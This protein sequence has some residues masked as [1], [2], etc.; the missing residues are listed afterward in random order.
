MLDFIPLCSIFTYPFA[1][2]F[3]SMPQ[4]VLGVAFSFGVPMAFTAVQAQLP[5]LAWVVSSGAIREPI[6][7]LEEWLSDSQGNRWLL[8][9]LNSGYVQKGFGHYNSLWGAV[10]RPIT[11]QESGWIL[12]MWRQEG[13]SHPICR[14]EA[15]NIVC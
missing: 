14:W 15:C 5:P 3:V 6:V 8:G 4:A 11:S 12:E 13:S 9:A 7:R 1:K 10:Y 2:R